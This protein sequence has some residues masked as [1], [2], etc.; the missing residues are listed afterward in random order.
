MAQLSLPL[1]TTYDSGNLSD[2][3]SLSGYDSASSMPKF[4]HTRAQLSAI[5]R[6]HKPLDN[7]DS[8]ADGEDFSRVSSSLVNKVVALL[9]DEQE[10][11]LKALLKEVYGMD[12][13]TV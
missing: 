11:E 9:V 8:D 5:A 1:T 10:D 6:Q 2:T 3:G 7:Y 12:G 13:E 4:P